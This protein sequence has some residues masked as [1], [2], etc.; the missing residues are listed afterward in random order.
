MI[1]EDLFIELARACARTCYALKTVTEERVV[2]GLRGPSEKQIEDL[3]RCVNPAQHSLLPI[4]SDNRIIRNIESGVIETANCDRDPP[5]HHPR[6]TEENLIAW[7]TEMWEKLRFFGVRG[8]Q[9][10]IPTVSELPQEDLGRCGALEIDEIE[11]HVQ[12]SVDPRPSAPVPVMVCC[13]F[14]TLAP[15]LADRPL[16]AGYVSVIHW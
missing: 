7:R 12:I 11:K 14:A 2:L 10:T 3:G 9:L 8:F 4:M 15:P 1:K 13:Y 5:E 6:S 16:N